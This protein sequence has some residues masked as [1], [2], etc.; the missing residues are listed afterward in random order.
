MRRRERNQF[1]A[2]PKEPGGRRVRGAVAAIVLA[3]VGA[4]GLVTF[5]KGAEDRAL[6]G[7]RLVTVFVVK[8]RVEA[9]TPAEEIKGHVRTERVPAKVRARGAVTDI[10]SLGGRVASV[11][12]VAGEQ[13]TV[14]RFI[15]PEVFGRTGGQ[16]DI[17][18]GKLEVTVSLEPQRAVGGVLRPG[19]TVAVLASFEPFD[20]SGG[21][22][23]DGA[24]VPAGGK[25]PNSTHLILHKVVV[26]NVQSAQTFSFGMGEGQSGA[27]ADEDGETAPAPSESLLVT[28][29]LDAPAVEQV[30][31]AAEHGT[32]WLAIEPTDA[33]EEGTRVQTRGT[34]YE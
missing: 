11:D 21:T 2:K 7:E 5:V 1:E 16:V 23:V 3:S 19:S 28:M 17:P 12:L 18:E 9:G 8:D 24:S 34:I 13:V 20:V 22:D 27:G 14:E 31:F 33:P 15:S 29:A 6:A 30:V 32:V 26:T 25:T 10:E 4:V